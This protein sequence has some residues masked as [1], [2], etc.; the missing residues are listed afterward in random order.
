MEEIDQAYGFLLY[1][2][3][4]L[5]KEGKKLLTIK[6]LRDRAVLLVDKVSKELKVE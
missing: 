6:G 3:K 2:T 4:L 5:A 1:R